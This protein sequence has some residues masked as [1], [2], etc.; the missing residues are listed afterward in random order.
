MGLLQLTHRIV[1]T[2]RRRHLVLRKPANSIAATLN[3]GRRRRDI[4]D[5]RPFTDAEGALILPKHIH[6]LVAPGHL[7][8]PLTAAAVAD[9]EQFP[10]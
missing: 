1:H 9:A 6:G 2:D 10:G 8:L 3:S 7:Q 5:A 4:H